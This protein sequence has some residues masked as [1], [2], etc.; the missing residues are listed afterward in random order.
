[1]REITSGVTAYRT[2]H[3]M[4]RALPRLT[5]RVEIE[6]ALDELEHLFEVIPPAMQAYAER[7]IEA[8]RKKLAALKS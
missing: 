2:W 1:M 4:A 8:S 3:D 6:T 7:V 5:Q